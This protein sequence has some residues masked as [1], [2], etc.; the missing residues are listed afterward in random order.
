MHSALRRMFLTLAG[1]SPRA[2]ALPPSHPLLLPYGHSIRSLCCP[3]P[4]SHMS[5]TPHCHPSISPK[6][7]IFLSGSTIF[8]DTLS[9]LI[10]CV[11]SSIMSTHCVCYP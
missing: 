9:P 4:Q 1:T 10:R 3:L 2:F 11:Q 7:L 6:T 5:H 8:D